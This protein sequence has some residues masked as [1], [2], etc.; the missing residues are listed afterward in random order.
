M[1][2][3]KRPCYCCG[4]PSTSVEHG[5]PRSMF[6]GWECDSITAPSCD[7]H[8]SAK[9][10]H[11]QA[12]VSALLIPLAGSGDRFPV[13]P[14]VKAA[15]ERARPSFQYSKRNALDVPLLKDPPEKMARLPNV[16]YLQPSVNI[17]E[18]V[19]QLT[20]VMVWNALQ[21]RDSTINWD[22]AAI[23]S[24]EWIESNDPSSLY[25][26]NALAVMIGKVGQKAQL[27]ELYWAEGWSAQP[28]PYPAVIYKFWLHFRPQ[29]VIFKHRFYNRYTWYAWVSGVSDATANALRSKLPSKGTV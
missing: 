5:P 23:W 4:A 16:S 28:R 3:A 21:E 13:E 1:A 27:E 19:K 6:K 20:E 14:E 26:A 24:A 15:I 10:G 8:N 12:I 25:T 29:E 17:K 2:R 18:W 11:D 7:K 22:E 9:S